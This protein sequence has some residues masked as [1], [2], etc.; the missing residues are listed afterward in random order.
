MWYRAEFKYQCA[1]P[2]CNSVRGV[3]WFFEEQCD[4]EASLQVSQFVP[5]THCQQCGT[6]LPLAVPGS[7]RLEVHR[8]TE[9][10]LEPVGL[11]D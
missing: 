9:E 4:T 6:R 5:G 7:F 3:E 1:I 2:S 11:L 10:E 8:A